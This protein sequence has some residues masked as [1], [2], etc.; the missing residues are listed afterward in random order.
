MANLIVNTIDG[1]EVKIAYVIRGKQLKPG[2]ESR[3]VYGIIS[4]N[5]DIILR[6]PLQK[7][8]AELMYDE[9]FRHIEEIFLQF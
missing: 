7:E 6:V 2:E 3:A 4:T 1:Y 5:S 9:N 8:M